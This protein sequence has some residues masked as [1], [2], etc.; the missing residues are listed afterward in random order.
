MGYTK[1]VP[2][3][4]EDIK[5]GNKYYT[6]NYSGVIGVTACKILDNDTVLIKVK[7][8]KIKPFVRKL[9]YLFDNAEMAKSACRDWE[10]D[11][12]KRKKR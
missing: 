10:S 5:V 7:N 8:D 1:P 4:R 2:M 6:C 11:E 3:K 9:I 12:K